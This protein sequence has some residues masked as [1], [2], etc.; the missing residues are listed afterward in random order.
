MKCHTVTYDSQYKKR[1]ICICRK[2]SQP[3]HSHSLIRVL[4]VHKESQD[5]KEYVVREGLDQAVQANLVLN[6]LY[7]A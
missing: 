1:S 7:V 4:T 6:C 2:Q 3:V 5:T